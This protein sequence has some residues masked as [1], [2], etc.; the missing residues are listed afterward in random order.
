M[1]GLLRLTRYGLPLGIGLGGA[2]LRLASGG[3]SLSGIVLTALLGF[4]LGSL[5]H[6]MLGAL[7]VVSGHPDVVPPPNLARRLEMLEKDKRILLRSIRE[8]EF[9]ASL[10]KLDADDAQRLVTPLKQRAMRLLKELD[11]A[12]V[13]E[14]SSV[15]QQIA[16]E[17]KS[18]LAE[19]GGSQ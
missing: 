13:N 11:A 18:R 6:N 16:N 2:L 3:T 10:Q 9:D 14:G 5:V 15:D 12:R 17:V 4:C 8:I 1:V 7:A 19:A